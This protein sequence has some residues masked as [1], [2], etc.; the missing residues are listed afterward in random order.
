MNSRH[1]KAREPSGSRL[2]HLYH[3]KFRT[4]AVKCTEA[5]VWNVSSV[6][7]KGA[8]ACQLVLM[9]TTVQKFGLQSQSRITMPA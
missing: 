5:L 4:R 6:M 3:F 8:F 1:T 7:D 2:L 9:K